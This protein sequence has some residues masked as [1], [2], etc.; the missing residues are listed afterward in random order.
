MKITFEGYKISKETQVSIK[1]YVRFGLRE[2][3]PLKENY[4]DSFFSDVWVVVDVQNLSPRD[5]YGECGFFDDPENP[6]YFELTLDRSITKSNRTYKEEHLL[7]S[8]VFHEVAH[9]YQ[10]VT[11][12]LKDKGIDGISYHEKLYTLKDISQMEYDQYPWEMEAVL[13]E[14]RLL[15]ANGWQAN[16]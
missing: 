7:A 2:L 10:F 9:I 8:T 1:S 15:N 5:H 4:K 12:H 11:G 16:A 3:C 14:S 6:K 13:M